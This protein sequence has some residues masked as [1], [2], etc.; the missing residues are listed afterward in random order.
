MELIALVV[1]IFIGLH[2]YNQNKLENET[3]Y[4]TES[5]A[6]LYIKEDRQPV[7][8]AF[9]DSLTSGAGVSKNLSYPAQLS[10]MLGFEVINAGKSGENTSMA[11]KRL[12]SVLNRYKPDIVIIAE[13]SNDLLHGKKRAVIKKNLLK[14]VKMINNSGAKAIILGM[15]DYDLIELMISSDIDLYEQVAEETKSY[16][17]GGVFGPVL[18]DEELKSD[19]V[20][21]NAKGYHAVAKKIYVEMREFL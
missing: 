20:H 2:F 10:D 4:D 1:A 5:E 17:I 12:P 8:V 19:H 6:P 3:F 14:M 13:G 9:G 7:I 16:Y 21:P 18:K 11:V 15:P